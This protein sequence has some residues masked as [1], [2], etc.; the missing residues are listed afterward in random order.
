MPVPSPPTITAPPTPPSRSDPTSFATRGDAFL[1][2]FPT[3]WTYLSNLAAWLTTRANEV[4]ANSNAA[5]QAAG[6]VSSIA[7]SDAVQNAASNAAAA[8]LAA[9]QAQAYATQAQATNPDSPVRL[10]P[11]RIAA[12]L[13]I[14]AGY[15]A[16]SVGP[17]SIDDGI[18]VTVSDN[19]TWSI[20]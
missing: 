15:N 7:A 3:A 13:T 16:A 4:E 17:I 14:P 18:V 12:A 1:G 10:N 20:H 6:T 2:W 11:R 8:Q 19:S 5:V 9:Q